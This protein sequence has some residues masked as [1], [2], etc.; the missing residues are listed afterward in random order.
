MEELKKRKKELE[1]YEKEIKKEI[2]DEKVKVKKIKD[3][4]E[5]IISGFKNTVN[6]DN[7]DNAKSI[8]SKS[9]V[10]PTENIKNVL[11]K[12]QIGELLV[13]LKEREKIVLELRLGL[14]DNKKRTL[15]EVAKELN[16]TSERIRQ[17]EYKAIKKLNIKGLEKYLLD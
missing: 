8:L 15:E 6:V 16:V 3:K 4:F 11:S 13:G 5:E 7:D 1:E 17:I 12:E 9:K 10:L 14:V 2:E